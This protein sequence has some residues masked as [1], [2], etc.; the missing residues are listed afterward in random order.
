MDG[1]VAVDDVGLTHQLLEQGDGGV[2][3]AHHQFVQRPAQPQQTF[4]A[5]AGM[6]NQLAH[7]AVVIGRDAI[8]RIDRRI[9]AYAQAPG[10]VELGDGAGRGA[11]RES[12]LR[13]DTTF[14]GMALENDVLLGKAQRGAGGDADLFAYDVDAGNGFADGMLHLQAGVHFDEIELAI[15]IEEFD[16][17][18]AQIAQL[19][20]R[21]GDDAADLIT[22]LCVQRRTASLFP[23]LLVTALQR[24]VAL[25]QMHDMA[26]GVGQNL[27]FDMAWPL[28]IFLHIDH[29]IAERGLG[30]GARLGQGKG[31]LAG[32]LG[33]F[34]APAAAPRRGLDQDR[35]ADLFGHA[36]GV[37]VQHF[38]VR[39]RHR[40]NAQFLHR[41][42][43]GDLVAHHPDMLGRGTD[44][45][46][47]MLLDDVGE[48]RVLRQ[49][50]V[51]GMNGLGAGDLAGSDDCRNVQIGL[52]GGGWADADALIGQAHMHRVRIRRGMDGHGGDAH[53]LAGA[54]DA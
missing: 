23:Q 5:V 51:A 39:A 31:K 13:I 53:L 9:E 46:Q 37:R 7:Q 16:G 42:L 22:L 17:A 48:L 1:I 38:A 24:A 32:I 52:G 33:D 41:L 36:R 8:A 14:D 28:E 27:D 43:G 45:G 18:G 3:A 4:V 40:G 21:L 35:I 49:E 29:V 30:F 12:I 54:D 19:G 25:A 44:E 2:D 34:H 26:M 50:A 15:L 11:E 20:Q 6:D 47:P 10:G